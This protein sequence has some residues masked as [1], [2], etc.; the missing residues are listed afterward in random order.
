MASDPAVRTPGKKPLWRNPWVLAGGGGALLGG[1]A[2]LKKRGGGAP[3][4]QVSPGAGQFIPSNFDDGGTGA[5]NNLQNEIEAFQQQLNGFASTTDLNELKTKLDQLQPL[6]P[7][8]PLPKT[9]PSVIPGKLNQKWNLRELAKYLTPAS[10]RNNPNAV[11]LELRALVAANPSW[12]G[13]TYVLGGHKFNN[14]V[15]T[16]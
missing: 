5:Y 13:K 6:S 12:R 3:D 7:G 14:P 2:L 9:V 15:V 4:A 8:S 1:I 11:E 16:G 10:K